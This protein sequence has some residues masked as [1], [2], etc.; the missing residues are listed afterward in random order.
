MKL[1]VNVDHVATLRQA[2]GVAYPDPVEA[3]R[4]AEQA[5]AA[6]ITVHL[7]G[8]RRHI[9]EADVERL[10]SSV[11]TKLNLEL[12]ATA[13]MVA[14][15]LRHRPDQVSLVPERP[16][17]VTTEGGLDLGRH[18]GRVEE[19]AARMAEA[20]IAVSLFLDPDPRQVEVAA[21]LPRELVAGFEINTDAYT[22]AAAAVAAGDGR[23]QQAADRTEAE[24]TLAE[25]LGQVRRAARLGAEAGLQVYA[26]HGLTSA[27]VGPIAAIPEIEELNIGHALISRAVLVGLAEAVRQMLRAMGEAER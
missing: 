2:R 22:R 26:G 20:G 23:R 7:R 14:I 12:A 27:N 10:R 19:A 6:G 8:D 17:E 1:A 18:R 9:Q 4:I 24:H 11:A 5:G 16:E 25:E 13:E 15:A 3:A 21:G